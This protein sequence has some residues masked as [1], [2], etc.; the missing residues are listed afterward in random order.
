MF[1][2]LSGLR[3]IE[4]Y[5]CL[6][7][8]KNIVNLSLCRFC[9]C[10]SATVID[11]LC[12]VF[13]FFKIHIR[14]LPHRQKHLTTY[15]PWNHRHSA[16]SEE[17]YLLWYALVPSNCEHV[18]MLMLPVSSNLCWRLSIFLQVYAVLA[19]SAPPIQF[20]KHGCVAKCCEN[21]SHLSLFLTLIWINGAYCLH[22]F[23]PQFSVISCYCNMKLHTL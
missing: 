5:I 15:F 14:R 12:Y 17:F 11:L 8:T 20:N 7:S 2:F 22:A 6:G 16:S 19:H 18:N 10:Y 9:F 1:V 13:F 21:S 23:F 4:L 3:P